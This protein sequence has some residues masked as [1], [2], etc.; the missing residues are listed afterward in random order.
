MLRGGRGRR[1]LRGNGEKF[2]QNKEKKGFLQ[3]KK[4]IRFLELGWW[5]FWWVGHWEQAT[6][7]LVENHPPPHIPSAFPGSTRHPPAVAFAF[8]QDLFP[9]FRMGDAEGSRPTVAPSPPAQPRWPPRWPAPTPAPRNHLEMFK[10]LIFFSPF[11]NFFSFFKCF[12][13]SFVKPPGLTSLLSNT[14]HVRVF[15]LRPRLSPC[16]AGMHRVP[17]PAPGCGFFRVAPRRII[18]AG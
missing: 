13:Q 17:V 8:P 9:T 5:F 7:D 10:L 11:L 1:G 18:G 3:K 2:K 15:S 16:P 12:P 6:L 14:N 4:K